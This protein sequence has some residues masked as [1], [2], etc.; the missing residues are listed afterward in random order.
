MNNSSSSSSSRQPPRRLRITRLIIKKKKSSQKQNPFQKK[1][2]LIQSI[3]FSP[4]LPISIPRR[5]DDEY[6]QQLKKEY[7]DSTIRLWTKIYLFE[8]EK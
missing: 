5:N 8:I 6:L 2:N 7:R 4:V 3:D 1:Q